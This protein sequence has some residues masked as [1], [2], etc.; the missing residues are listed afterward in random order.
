MLN[1]DEPGASKALTEIIKLS[2]EAFEKPDGFDAP[3]HPPGTILPSPFDGCDGTGFLRVQHISPDH[4]ARDVSGLRLV[5]PWTCRPIEQLTRGKLPDLPESMV[6]TRAFTVPGYG[7]KGIHQ[8]AVASSIVMASFMGY[9]HMEALIVPRLRVRGYLMEALGFR[10]AEASRYTISHEGDLVECDFNDGHP[11]QLLPIWLRLDRNAIVS[12][13]RE[14]KR[15]ARSRFSELGVGVTFDHVFS[16][17]FARA[18]IDL[19]ELMGGENGSYSL[20]EVP[21]PKRGAFSGPSHS[22]AVLPVEFKMA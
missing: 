18:R 20:P 22:S 2:S 10:I 4:S 8:F 14:M 19:S 6:Y 21:N 16:S 5:R 17:A 12:A 11:V 7:G 3:I 9:E 1:H 15:I 13:W